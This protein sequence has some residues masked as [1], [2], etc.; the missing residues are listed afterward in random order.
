MITMISNLQINA[1]PFLALFLSSARRDSFW[2]IGMLGYRARTRKPGQPG[3]DVTLLEYGPAH[4]VVNRS[5][6]G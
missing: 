3:A 2:Q 5:A 1:L 6:Q 4:D